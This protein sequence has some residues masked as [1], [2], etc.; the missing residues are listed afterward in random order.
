MF[1]LWLG[2]GIVAGLALTIALVG[3]GLFHYLC[4][5]Y[6]DFVVRVFEEK[7]LFIIPTGSPRA[8]AEEVDN[9]RPDRDL[10]AK[11]EAVEAPVAQQ[12]P[13]AKLGIGRREPHCASS[14]AFARR[15]AF[16]D[17][18]TSLSSGRAHARPPSPRGRRDSPD[19]EQ[20]HA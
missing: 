7:P 16:I 18:H 19:P 14:G 5:R 20:H 15:D 17:L 11:L 13:K 9:I 2:L 4:S 12:S 1:W 3:F 10:P 8:D 6:L